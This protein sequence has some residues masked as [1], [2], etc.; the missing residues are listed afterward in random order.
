[1]FRGSAG[2]VGGAGPRSLV[3]VVEHPVPENLLIWGLPSWLES[4]S[5]YVF[6]RGACNWGGVHLAGAE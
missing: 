5:F 1:M 3:W 2:P 6:L 4:Q